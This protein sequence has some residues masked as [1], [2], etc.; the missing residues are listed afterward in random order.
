[1]SRPSGG[2]GGAAAPSHGPVSLLAA[3]SLAAIGV[4]A[5]VHRH[6]HSNLYWDA[7]ES[8]SINLFLILLPRIVD[9]M[10]SP[11]EQRCFGADEAQR[12]RC[13]HQMRHGMEQLVQSE[14]TLRWAMGDAVADASHGPNAT[15]VG[16]W[17]MQT[18]KDSNGPSHSIEVTCTCPHGSGPADVLPLVLFFH[19]GGLIVGSVASELHMARYVAHK[20]R[21]VVCTPDYRLAPE[22]PYPAGLD[23]CVAA[24][25]SVL[26]DDKNR[27]VA[28]SLGI[29]GIDPARVATFGMSAGGYLAAHVA[30]ELTASGHDLALQ[31]S[32]VPM[33]QPYGGG[34]NSSLFRN[35]NA[36]L[37]N[38]PTNVWA[39]SLYL[40][41]D[42]DGSLGQNPRVN[43][44]VDPPGGPDV[45]RRLPPAY[46][47]IH[48]K[49]ALRDEGE[50]YA[51]RLRGQGKLWRL[52]EYNT[53]HVGG[54]FPGWARGGPGE[55]ALEDA[56]DVVVEA[57]AVGRAQ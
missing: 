33:V 11:V 41:D 55:R 4:A 22:Y 3:I 35:W 24:A 44:L 9:W 26:A 23:D 43:L 10:Q 19:S 45:L 6:S 39:W 18:T 30:R 17:E 14:R 21:T 31:V 32:L 1:M 16:T 7:D 46:V 38:G 37:W 49:D 54:A 48:S 56:V 27:R 15:R 47:Q 36:P 29:G 13:L 53:N 20:S 51:Q 40:A 12:A 28:A 50:R 8:W 5:W 52:D 57:F 25:R 2:G 34:S 42:A